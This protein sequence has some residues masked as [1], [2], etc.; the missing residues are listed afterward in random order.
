MF[1]SI[2]SFYLGS[3]ASICGSYFA[4]SPLHTCRLVL[5]RLC[6][7]CS[8][9]CLLSLIMH[10]VLFDGLFLLSLAFTLMAVELIIL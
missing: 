7:N 3:C 2:W 9:V 6:V 4:L 1:E 8:L 10:Y 5:F